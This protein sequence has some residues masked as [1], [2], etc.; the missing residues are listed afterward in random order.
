MTM[1]IEAIHLLHGYEGCDLIA[2]KCPGDVWTIG[3]GTTYYPDGSRI[4]E[5]DEI[6]EEQADEYFMDHVEKIYMQIQDLVVNDDWQ[7]EAKISALVC[8]VYNIGVRA[9]ARSTLLKRIN[10]GES[11]VRIAEA[12]SW[13]NKSNGKTLRGLVRRRSAEIELALS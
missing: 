12:W 9:F 5:G 4:Q 13:W 6:T 8:L 7:S 10:N 1:T 11:D 3:Y 2:Y